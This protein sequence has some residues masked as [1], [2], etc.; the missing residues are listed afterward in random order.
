MRKENKKKKTRT[1]KNL[2]R[3]RGQQENHYLARVP[4]HRSWYLSRNVLAFHQASARA[5][6]KTF[7]PRIKRQ[8]KAKDISNPHI[9]C[10]NRRPIRNGKKFTIRLTIQVSLVLVAPQYENLS[11]KLTENILLRLLTPSTPLKSN[12]SIL[13]QTISRSEAWSNR[14]ILNSRLHPWQ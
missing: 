9:T 14:V 12:P 8:A 13:I 11:D 6:S 7:C 3:S 1:S 5:T 10:S 4:S 2:L